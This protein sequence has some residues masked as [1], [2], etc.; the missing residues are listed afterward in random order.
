MKMIVKKISKE[1]KDLKIFVSNLSVSSD[2]FT[3]FKSRCF[4]VL[5][6]HILTVL[7]YIKN[8]PVAYGHLDKDGNNIWLGVCV[9]GSEVGK[10]Y[11][12]K[13]MDFL[14]DS[15]NKEKIDLKLSV[16]KDNKIAIKLYKNYSF[17]IV[18]QDGKNIFMEKKYEN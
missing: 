7:G 11:G 12:K 14:I 5:D 3:Y 18:S 8:S 4:D 17:N 1:S 16:K 9:V 15:A 6:N 2:T 13:M 10:G